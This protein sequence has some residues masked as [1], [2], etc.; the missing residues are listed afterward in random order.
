M[1]ARNLPKSITVIIQS[2][3]YN[4]QII[5]KQKQ[6][7]DVNSI[8]E[9]IKYILQKKKYLLMSYQDLRGWQHCILWLGVADVHG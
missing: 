6:K 8:T 1:L 3:S 9:Y 5:S 4:L 7:K 2:L